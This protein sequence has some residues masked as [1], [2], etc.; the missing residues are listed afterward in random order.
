[1]SEDASFRDLIVRVR[2]GDEQAAAT[3]VQRY[4]PAIRRAARLRLRDERLRR[5]LD[6]MD[7]CQ[8]VLASFFLRAATGQYELDTPD[9][10]LRLLA[11]MARHKVADQVDHQRAARRDHRR[12]EAGS[13]EDREV[14]G[15]EATPSR[16]V[17][18]RELLEETRRRL[19]PEERH[20]LDLRQQG[21]EWGEIA[22]QVG[23]SQEAL[24]KKLTRAVDR[25]AQELGLDE[26]S[27]E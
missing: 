9:Q 2:A 4:E 11:T 22:A 8:S 18:A 17:A 25:V 23:G 21:L 15:P 26:V 13:T 27:H 3:L 12:L 1:M 10:L 19:S 5:V 20:L 14:V 24:R 16:Y 6:S 7:I